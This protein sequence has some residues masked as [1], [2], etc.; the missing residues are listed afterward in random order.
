MS[1]PWSDTTKRIIAV[2][3]FLLAVLVVYRFRSIIGPLV[4]ALIIAY[5]LT[6]V[7]DALQEQTHLPRGLCVLLVDIFALALVAVI[8][9]V[10]A[11]ALISE[12][13]AVNVDVQALLESVNSYLSGTVIVFGFPV[14]LGALY[15]QFSASLRSL[16][17][18]VV[19]GGLFFL[20]DLATGLLWSVFIFV[21][22]LYLMRDW[23]RIAHYLRDVVPQ[24]Y[25]SDYDQMMQRIR[26]IWQAFFRGQ[27]VL[28]LVVGT[29]V[30]VTTGIA[31][32]SSALVLGL[33]S[34][35]LEAIPNVGPV[36]AAIPAV[37]LALVRGSSWIPLPN[38][39]FA[40]LVAGIYVVI[41]QVENNYLVP[42]IIG[43]SVK[44]HPMVVIVGALAGARLAG[45]LGIFLAAPVL[46]TIRVILSY[47]YRKLLDLDP[48]AEP[49]TAGPPPPPS[50][51]VSLRSMGDAISRR[52]RGSRRPPS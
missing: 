43:G 5:I 37:L 4:I 50:E 26:H 44:L 13:S 48:F 51:G 30:A 36:L 33:L 12:I 21:V 46:A 32:V 9:A 38:L 16:I 52:L 22:S 18:P 34:A 17:S 42:R 10:V 6:P 1:K 28:S 40:V 31:G 47:T 20:L 19:S 49:V 3:L 24:D 41:Q 2:V 35:L 8:P 11:P 15:E 14:D 25:R 39:W 23:H 7:V 29:A 27:I 45:V